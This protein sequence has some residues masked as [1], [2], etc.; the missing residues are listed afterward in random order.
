MLY[1]YRYGSE[2]K[3]RHS[4]DHGKRIKRFGWLAGEKWVATD[5]Q[6]WESL[7][8]D[9][10]FEASLGKQKARPNVVGG[11]LRMLPRIVGLSH[12]LANGSA[13]LAVNGTIRSLNG[14][15]INGKAVPSLSPMPPLQPPFAA[16]GKSHPKVRCKALCASPSGM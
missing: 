13:A 1:W 8:L 9:P 10:D 12:D 7:D 2:G 15:P 6:G 14:K 16:N 5:T 4:V 11:L 3:G